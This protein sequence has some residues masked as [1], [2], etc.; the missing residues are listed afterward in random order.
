MNSDVENFEQL[1]RLLALKRH[2]QPHPRYFNDFSSQVVARIKA[3]DKGETADG[4][5]WLFGDVSWLQRLWAT[6]ESKPAL[7]GAFGAA[8]CAMLVAGIVYSANV[9]PAPAHAAGP[10]MASE[11]VMSFVSS[12]GAAGAI[13][14]SLSFSSTNG[15]SPA[16]SL[17]D[18]FHAQ[19]PFGLPVREVKHS[20][21]F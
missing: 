19:N 20:P 21:G 8:V 7:A 16:G 4:L 12:A 15:V 10:L 6:L 18:Q 1:R 2:E 3:G 17:F 9:E 11:G 5:D 14:A 13:D